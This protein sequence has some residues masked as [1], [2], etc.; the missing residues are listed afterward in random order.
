MIPDKYRLAARA[1]AVHAGGTPA[2]RRELLDALGLLDD[3]GQ[4]RPYV[5]R[6]EYGI[7]AFQG[8]GSA[9][10]VQGHVDHAIAADTRRRPADLSAVPPGLRDYTPEGP[11][12]DK[13]RRRR[14]GRRAA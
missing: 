2:E 3:D 12:P 6:V 14:G 11:M 4:V 10:G 5:H 8:P 9:M 1:V 7:D 13:P